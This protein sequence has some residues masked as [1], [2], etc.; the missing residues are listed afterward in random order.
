MG[1]A[2]NK[3]ATEMCRE[4]AEESYYSLI[5]FHPEYG[6]SK[7]DIMTVEHNYLIY[8]LMI[9]V[10]QSGDTWLEHM[11]TQQPQSQ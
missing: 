2:K 4:F 1:T 5:R 11:P 10:E 7:G 9:R 6:T 8:V 3:E